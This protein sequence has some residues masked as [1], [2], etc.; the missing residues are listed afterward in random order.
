MK[1]NTW[2]W[3]CEIL[4]PKGGIS[5]GSQWAT[6]KLKLK[7]E[8]TECVI[9]ANWLR[10]ETLEGRLP[11]VWHHV[12]NEFDGRKNP[13]FGA[14]MELLGRVKGAP[15]YVFLGK[16]KCFYIEMKSKTGRVSDAQKIF[17]RWC[18][19]LEVSYFICKSANEAIELIKK[20]L[21]T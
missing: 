4:L 21:A 17:S 11:F 12:P 3:L 20:E 8:D 2:H 5:L 13:V 9:L 15:D 1:S 7:E 10:A 6:K 18:V 16:N 19:A 14:K